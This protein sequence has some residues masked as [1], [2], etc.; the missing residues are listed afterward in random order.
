MADN[1]KLINDALPWLHGEA[2]MAQAVAFYEEIYPF[3]GNQEL[4]LL[5]QKDRFF[6]ATHILGRKDLIHPWQYDRAREIERNPDGYLDLWAREHGKSSWITFAGIIQEV[7]N[8][9]EITIGIFSFNKPTARKFLRQIKYEFESNEQLKRLYPDTL[10]ADPKKESPRWSEDSGIV[11][12]RKGN[13]KEATVEGHGLVDGQPTGAH[14]LLRV[15]DDVVTV[16]SVTS[17]EMVQKTTE[18]WALSDNLGARGETGMARSWHIGTRYCTVADTKILMADWTH[19]RIADVV[20][21]DVVVGWEQRTGDGKRFLRQSVVKATGN[22]EKQPVNT[23]T[24]DSGRS[25][26][27]TP[28]HQWWRGPHGSGGEYCPLTV[29]APRNRRN[30][31]IVGVN[32]PY[33]LVGQRKGLSWVRELLVPLE[34][35]GRGHMRHDRCV[36]NINGGWRERYR[37]LAQIKPTKIRKLAPTLFAQ[38][39]T[40]KR[41][42]RVAENAG[43]QDVYWLETETGNYVA[44]GFCSKNSFQDTY[45]TMMDMGAVIPRI[46]PATDTGYRDGDPVFLPKDVWDDKKKRQTT[47]VLAAQMLQNPSAGT[48]AIFDKEW[49]KFSDIRPATLNIYI[50][51]DP[52]SSKKK[53]SDKTAIPVVGIDSAGNKWLVDGWHHKM[54]L[55]ERYTRIKELRKLWMRM[56]GVQ[57]VK[58]G[59]ERYGSTSD[60]EHF[61]IEMQRDRDEFEIVELAW[62]REGPGSKIDRVQRLEPDFRNGRFYLP[63]KVD[64]ET[65][66]Q[67]RVKAEGQPFR[68]FSPVQRTDEEGRLYSLNKNF[69]EEFL[70]FPFCAHDDLIDAISRIYDIDAVPPIIIDERSLDPECFA[71]GI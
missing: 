24:F 8:D 61:E 2:T 37:F 40:E 59:Y 9:P 58:V 22:H 28:D 10:Y 47:T 67:A 39:Q 25:V 69:L 46:Y 57:S 55:A 21:G 7:I 54:G 38:M 43:H 60:L 20:V 48:A 45:Q 14:F 56:P 68:V 71:D 66:A 62:P 26:I 31:G 34:P 13:P 70:T 65:K 4:A 6:L 41:S 5:G 18:A 29:P 17:P 49:L 51:C 16:D 30:D 19:K 53:G 32:N 44:N 27:C 50:L 12:K 33:R 23:Y 42:L 35:D 64:G 36:F 11:V 63:A 52:A 15:Y 1:L 3:V